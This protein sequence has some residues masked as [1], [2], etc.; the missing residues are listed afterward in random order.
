MQCK[1]KAES[2][3]VCLAY[4]SAATVPLASVQSVK[5]AG[6]RVKSES[7]GPRVKSEP[8]GPRVKIDGYEP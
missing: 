4:R 8:E 1:L 7:E 2:V 6:P 5:S 3:T